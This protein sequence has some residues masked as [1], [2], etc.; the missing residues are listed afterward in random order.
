MKT[1]YITQ[2]VNEYGQVNVYEIL[3]KIRELCRFKFYR[4]ADKWINELY[5][6]TAGTSFEN[7]N[8]ELF[9]MTFDEECEFYHLISLISKKLQ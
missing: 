4:V 3:C 9:F 2:Y 7:V 6:I 8:N 1:Q 5:E